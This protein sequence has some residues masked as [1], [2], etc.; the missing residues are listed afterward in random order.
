MAKLADRRSRRGADIERARAM[1]VRWTG[2]DDPQIEGTP[3]EI[4][5]D[6]AAL[7]A[8]LRQL[9]VLEIQAARVERAEADVDL[10]RAK[11]RPDFTVNAAYAHR[12]PEYGEYVSVGI[13]IDLPIFAKKRQNPRINARMLEVDAARL[14]T[15]DIKRQ[16]TADLSADLADNRSYRENWERS[17]D[18]LLPLARRQAELDRISY[19]ANRVDLGTALN[20]AVAFAEAEIDLLDREATL[21]RDT[22]RIQFTNVRNLP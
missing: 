2:I 13:T 12:R 9:P 3:P 22:V 21:V 20:S 16:L 4:N 19:S 15:S 1:L 18:T 14:E 7:M 8:K 10:A 17:R 5:L 6:R 11:K